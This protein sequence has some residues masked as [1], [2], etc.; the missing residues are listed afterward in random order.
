MPS[1]FVIETADCLSA[2]PGPT[3][4][5]TPLAEELERRR[6]SHQPLAVSIKKLDSALPVSAG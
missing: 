2:E 3:K 4:G 5:V 6:W 1:G